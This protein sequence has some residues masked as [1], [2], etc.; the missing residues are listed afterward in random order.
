MMRFAFGAKFGKPGSAPVVAP[1]R[2]RS[3]SVARAAIPMPVAVRPKKWRRVS[4]SIVL[5]LGDHLIQIEDEA[6][7]CGI[8]RE[9]GRIDRLVARRV[10]RVEI[11]F[12]G[13]RVGG[14]A[15]LEARES[16]FQDSRFGRPDRAVE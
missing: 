12:G 11:L 14:V 16:V 10:S 1:L 3:R 9:F 2:S 5:F 4:A 15:G 13:F 7:G 6:G 8:G